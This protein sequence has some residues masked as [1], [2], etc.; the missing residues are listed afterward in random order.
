MKRRILIF[1]DLRE[2]IGS[3]YHLMRLFRHEICRKA[4][5]IGVLPIE[6]RRMQGKGSE[7]LEYGV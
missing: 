3:E 7:I 4:S 1:E 5:P 2:S 6:T